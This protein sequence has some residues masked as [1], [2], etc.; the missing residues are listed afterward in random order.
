MLP[1]SLVV[2]DDIY[3]HCIKKINTSPSKFLG[4]WD[5]IQVNKIS[6]TLIFQVKYFCSNDKEDN[7]DIPSTFH[8]LRSRRH[9]IGVMW[10]GI[11]SSLTNCRSDLD[12]TPMLVNLL[13]SDSNFSCG[14]TSRTTNTASRTSS[15]NADMFLQIWEKVMKNNYWYVIHLVLC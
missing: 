6:S 8:P 2:L 9:C 3:I 12:S 4:V 7:H 13:R 5:S 11:S 1:L 10:S 15:P 14:S